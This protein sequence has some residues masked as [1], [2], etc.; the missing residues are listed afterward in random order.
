MPHIVSQNNNE[1]RLS[2]YP[3]GWGVSHFFGLSSFL[4]LQ[5]PHT[6]Q[7]LLF[8]RIHGRHY[9]DNHRQNKRPC[10]DYIQLGNI[11]R[12][13]DI[14]QIVFGRQQADG[15]GAAGTPQQIIQS[16]LS[17]IYHVLKSGKQLVDMQGCKDTAE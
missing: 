16:G 4:L 5:L 1:N 15:F 8:T 14:L 6:L 12:D 17:S 9:T 13:G 10:S 2:I 11:Q 7:R 3:E